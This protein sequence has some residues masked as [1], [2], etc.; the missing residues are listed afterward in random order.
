MNTQTTF[1]L[2]IGFMLCSCNHKYEG[3]KYSETPPYDWENP[4]IFEMHKED[5]VATFVHATTQE[6]ALKQNWRE[7]SR[8]RSLNGVW[9]FHLARNFKERPYYFFKDDYDISDWEEAPVPSNWQLQGTFDPPI[10]VNASY[11]FSPQPPFVP[12]EYNPV[13]SYKRTFFIPSE[14]KSQKVFIHF[15]AVSSAMYVWINGQQIGYSQGSK[16]PAVFNISKYIKSGRNFVSVQIFRWSD[17]SYLEDQDFWRLSGMTRDV[18]L[19][20]TPFVALYDL[21]ANARLF[22]NYQDGALDLDIKVRNSH[23]YQDGKTPYRLAVSLL[24]PKGKSLYKEEKNIPLSSSITS[25]N[26]QHT[27]PNIKA[28]SA[29][30]PNLYTLLISLYDKQGKSLD[31][32]ARQIGF[33]TVEIKNKLLCVNG[34]PVTVK[35]VNLHEHNG[36]TGHVQNKKMMMKD[37][38]LMKQ[39]NINTVRTSH[40]PQPPE[41]YELCDK[42]GLYVID[43]A[44]IESH[45]MGYGENSLAKDPEW[46]AAHLSRTKR[47]VER[48][49]NHPSIILWSLGN[50]AGD[51]IN[52]EAT[53]AWI[54]SRDTSRP[55][56]YERAGQMPHTDIVCPMYARIHQLEEY[57]ND[58]KSY[59]PYILCEYAHAMG[60]S[61]GNLQDY[62]DMIEK[63]DIL[64]GGCIWDWVDQG[65]RKTDSTGTSYWAYGG[66][67]GT[68]VPTEGKFSDGNF[69]INGLVD[70]DRTAKPALQEVKKV[71]QYIGFEP[72]NS[73]QK[74]VRIINKYDFTDLSSF[75]IRWEVK[76]QGEVIDQGVLE[77]F[78][79]APKEERVVTIAYEIKKEIGGAEY[80]LNFTV[81]AKE[82]Y[83]LIPAGYEVA[84]EQ[85]ALPDYFPEKKKPKL[86]KSIRTQKEEG[87]ITFSGEGFEYVFD[88]KAG[89]LISLKCENEE[90]LKRGLVPNFW[91]APIDN[92]YGNGHDIRCRVWRKIG[93]RRVLKKHSV[94]QNKSDQI[95]VSLSFH[96]DLPDEEGTPLATLNSTYTV[97]G[98]G[99]LRVQNQ[100][101]ILQTPEPLPYIPLI[102]MNMQLRR[103]YDNMKWLGRGPHENYIDRKTSAKVDLYSGKVA[104]QYWA[105][106]RPQE[107]GNKTDVRWASFT[108]DQG[109]GILIKASPLFE[110]SAHH[111]VMED[112]ESSAHRTA[113]GQE[114]KNR[115][116]KDVKPRDLVS[117]NINHKQ[118]GVGGDDSW[119][120]QTHDEYKLLEKSYTYS[121]SI[122]PM[123]KE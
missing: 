31:H 112:F 30:A 89:V 73:A 18:Y 23:L 83:S 28:W 104:E 62:W 92:D 32:T 16:T 84:M 76:A 71:Y 120:A 123:G 41:W 90:L 113:A 43:E 91:R 72:V 94:R 35:G 50:E 48:D 74:K 102:G 51:G 109:K 2:L 117:I 122:F 54:K 22:N 49:K 52:F 114:V 68:P 70:P 88:T 95:A 42:Y 44:N 87:K 58:K 67:F 19:Y 121:F 82:P 36:I 15:G 105:Y 66:D 37:V 46:K 40:Y 3:V 14:W 86:F 24:D 93:D 103:E 6:E 101:Q 8:Y 11:P 99:E 4:S 1:C 81:L 78:S 5:P 80:F 56:H 53:S 57:A 21:W 38:E 7:S 110:M 85:I 20:T 65:L 39:F 79:L 108:N 96:F 25:V 119:G 55:V 116:T 107:N 64:Q 17:G 27:F 34:V 10:Y 61:V 69:C 47:M 29:E 45:G 60:N 13:G 63:Y 12:L 59:R 77:D 9:K 26:F 33:R 97:T 98:D 118:M 115:H 100:F 106:I 75:E 111:N